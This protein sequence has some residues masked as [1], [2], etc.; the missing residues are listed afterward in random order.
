MAHV[1]ASP[2]PR[3]PHSEPVLRK[4]KRAERT[5]QVESRVWGSG[6]GLAAQASAST[7]RA[8]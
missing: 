1:S 3:S 7:V 2:D 8:W 5:G 6:D 4:V